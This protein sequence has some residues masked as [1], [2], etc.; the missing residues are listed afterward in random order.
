[1]S[2]V[3]RLLFVL[4]ASLLASCAGQQSSQP[5]VDAAQPKARPTHNLT[6]FDESLRCM[7]GLFL[8]HGIK[9]VVITSQGIPDATGEIRTGSKEMLISAISRMSTY[10]G[11]FRFVDYD[12][13]Q[14][15]INELQKLVG[16][17]EDF[18][19]PNY[20]I[21]G[22][23][24]Q[25]DEQVVSDSQ[26]GG[27]SL[28]VFD[29]GASKN[30]VTSL[31]SIDLNVGNLLTRQIL[32]GTSA[33]NTIAVSRTGKSADSNGSISKL[34]LGFSFNVNMG[35]SEGMHQSVRTLLQLSAIESLGKLTEVP[36]W[37]CLGLGQTSTAMMEQARGWYSTMSKKEQRL[38][39]Q[40]AL[41]GL[42]IYSGTID[43]AASSPLQEAIGR[44][45]SGKNLLA[46]GKINF[47]LYASLISEDLALG[48]SPSVARP[49]ADQRKV[50][51]KAKLAPISNSNSTP[52]GL[53]LAT[54]NN[55]TNYS[56]GDSL[57]ITLR[58][59][60]DAFAYCYYKDGGGS[61]VRLYPNRFQPNALISAG[62]TTHI[63]GETSRFEI[64]LEQSGVEE[65]ILCLASEQELGI[66]LPKS[67]KGKDLTPLPI[68]SLSAV[69]DVFESLG[70]TPLVSERLLIPVSL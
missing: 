11:A 55:Q 70:D 47:Q 33:T 4:L 24:T 39:V 12:Q 58:S 30:K 37:Q 52:L 51:A 68:R 46:D 20:Y 2:S 17:T 38:F 34:S 65:E 7:D 43:G 1:M 41:S 16:F 23:I 29:V 19:V 45:Q 49:L 18:L 44:Y 27:L 67:L 22:A 13:R 32:T 69:A 50:S 10:S 35:R 59:T 56:K 26:S 60:E 53:V 36:Y 21:R 31:V 6:S 3:K 40:R 25:F 64:A 61:V 9:D 15:D 62:K 28:D 14:F 63:P 42:G 66:A 54:R 8:D 48:Q 5:V 57:F